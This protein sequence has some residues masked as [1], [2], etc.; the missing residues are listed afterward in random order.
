MNQKIIQKVAEKPLLSRHYRFTVRELSSDYHWKLNNEISRRY[1]QMLANIG[2]LDKFLSI[3][4]IYSELVQELNA[5]TEVKSCLVKANILPTVG[6]AAVAEN[7][8][9]AVPSVPN[10][11]VNYTALGTGTNTPANGDTTLQTETFRKLTASGNGVSNAAIISAF[12]TAAET[13]GT[14]R[15]AGLF[16]NGTASA[17]SGTLF[18]RIAINITKTTSQTLTI[19]YTITVS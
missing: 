3:R 13:S 7:L 6:R 16:I 14:F 15:E 4:K 12:Y 8:A 11:Y 5:I 2:N 19:D 17:N 10:I 9:E 18:S 1:E